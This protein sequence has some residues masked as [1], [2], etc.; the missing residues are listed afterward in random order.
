MEIDT[1]TRDI[2]VRDRVPHTPAHRL[3]ETEAPRFP[4]PEPLP[5][6]ARP[7][8]PIRCEPGLAY[9]GELITRAEAARMAAYPCARCFGIKI[10]VPPHL[11]DNRLVKLHPL[12][13]PPPAPVPG[14]L[15]EAGQ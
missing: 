14:K 15:A 12:L 6:G 9:G 13:P 1:T 2:W 7:V 8:Y 10:P 5:D 11:A 3:S 4:D